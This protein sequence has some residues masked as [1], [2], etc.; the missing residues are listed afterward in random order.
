MNHGLCQNRCSRGAVAGDIVGLGCNLTD[1]LGS[2]ILKRILQLDL[3]G[4][5]HAVVGDHRTSIG[6]IQNHI[7]SLRSDRD[8]NGIRQFIYTY[9]KGLSCLISIFQFFCHFSILRFFTRPLPEYRSSCRE[10]IP[11]LQ[12]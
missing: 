12:A 4:D 1:K 9:A 3:L 7:S 10:Y 5:R 8:A 11:R 6:L 2:H